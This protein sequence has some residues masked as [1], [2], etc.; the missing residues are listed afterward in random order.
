A[1]Y[2]EPYKKGSSYSRF[3]H[4]VGCFLLLRRFGASIEEQIAGLI[5][6]VSHSAFSHCIDYALD[7]GSQLK[8]TYQDSIF[9][10]FVKKTEIPKILKKYNFNPDY[11]LE[12]KNFPLQEVDVPDLCADRIDYSL[13]TNIL[14]EGIDETEY[15][16]DHLKTINN[17]WVFKDFKSAQKYRKMFSKINAKYF[18]GIDSARM[19]QT[20]GTWL[21]YSLSK[22]Y[23]SKKDLY[24]TDK[25]VLKKVKA[26]LKSDPE[27]R[28]L[29]DRMNRKVDSNNNIS[30]YDVKVFCKSRVVDPLCLFKGKIKRVSEI[31]LRWGKNVKKE[32]KPKEY[33]L[34]FD[35]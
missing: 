35:K 22:K 16:L 34:K 32:L 12:E 24:S 6:D 23:I 15:F 20:V 33:F 3:E 29:F 31:D 11:V 14:F 10:D 26:N 27:L 5:H 1:G 18:S 25:E 17:K 30:D 13:R 4:S 2:F 7:E 9:I 28:L 21:R 8:H 19:L